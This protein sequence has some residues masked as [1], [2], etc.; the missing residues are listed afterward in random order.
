MNFN[1]VKKEVDGKN[2]YYIEFPYTLKIDVGDENTGKSYIYYKLSVVSKEKDSKTS[3]G[4]GNFILEVGDNTALATS[5]VYERFEPTG[6]KN[7]W[8]LGGL[9]GE[10]P[11]ALAL[12][13]RFGKKKKSIYDDIV[14]EDDLEN[15]ENQ[16][17]FFD[18]ESAPI[19]TDYAQDLARDYGIYPKF[20]DGQL[21]FYKV[22]KGKDVPYETT[23]KT[24]QELY[25]MKER[26]SGAA[27]KPEKMSNPFAG[28]EDL[29]EIES[30]EQPKGVAEAAANFFKERM[31]QKGVQKEIDDLKDDNDNCAI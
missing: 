27:P 2:K 21:S 20:V 1:V 22:E 18:P 28:M 3:P 19:Y 30:E 4:I 26:E 11:T 24:V 10:M 16:L 25:E 12:R 13:D 8:R 14:P 15:I 6:S 5:A 7:Q 9:T 23:A 31:K 29:G 17:A